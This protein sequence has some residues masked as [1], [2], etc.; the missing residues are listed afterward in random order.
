[1]NTSSEHKEGLG[2]Q[3]EAKHAQNNRP[4]PKR[5]IVVNDQ[6]FPMPGRFVKVAAI[7]EQAN[8]PKDHV[9]IR[10]H[11]SPHD[12]LMPENGTADLA[13]GTVFYSLPVCDV[14]PRSDCDAPAKRVVDV[15]DR[16]EIVVKPEQSGRSIRDLFSLPGEIELLKDFESPMDEIIRDEAVVNLAEGEVFRT[17]RRHDLLTIIVNK[18][19]FNS[20]QGVKPEMTGLEIAALVYDKPENTAVFRLEG[21]KE[22]PVGLTEK[23]KIHECEAF[24][25]IRKDVNA[26]FQSSRIEHEIDKLRENGVNI[27]LLAEPMPAVVYL[28]VPTRPGHPVESTDVLVKVPGGYPAAFIDNAF[29]P[30]GSPLL[31]RVP[32]GVQGIETFGGRQWRQISIH[33][34]CGNGAAWNKD[35]YGFHTYYDEILSWLYKAN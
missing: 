13:E 16:W 7:K 30:E 17:R 8:I 15:D 14:K 35:R 23:I 32:G 34:Y 27:M 6:P 18:K 26:G 4:A 24:K 1:M 25:V 19:K 21:E 33:P 2:N 22:I 5:A 31:G 10:D 3:V 12:V 11:N 20:T 9:L 28:G 29:L